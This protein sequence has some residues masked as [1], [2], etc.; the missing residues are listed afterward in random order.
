MCFYVSGDTQGLPT[1]HPGDAIFLALNAFYG[2]SSYRGQWDW[3]TDENVTL[4]GLTHC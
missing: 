1:W 3:R 2:P 4:Q